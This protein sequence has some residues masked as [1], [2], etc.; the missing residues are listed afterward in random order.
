MP[1]RAGNDAW[2]PE[3]NAQSPYRVVT[4]I[5]VPASAAHGS[6]PVA[7]VT[8]PYRDETGP[9][10]VNLQQVIPVG[11]PVIY[12]YPQEGPVVIHPAATNDDLTC[13]IV[14]VSLQLHCRSPCDIYDSLVQFSDVIPSS[15][16]TLLFYPCVGCFFTPRVSSHRPLCA[17]GTG[18]LLPHCW[19]H[20]WLLRVTGPCGHE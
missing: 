19:L 6:T 9:G 16:D 7:R 11:S 2:A 14:G 18:D 13:P 20:H 15:Y 10:V 1:P 12:V 4:G 3:H 8:S 5:A 17:V